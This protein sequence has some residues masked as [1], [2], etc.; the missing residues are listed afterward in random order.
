M[1]DRKD[2]KLT[3]DLLSD[4]DADILEAASEVDR[5]LITWLLGLPPLARVSWAAR[6]AEST[7]GFKLVDE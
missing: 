3:A 4:I 7:K 5:T 6:I 2:E 1:K